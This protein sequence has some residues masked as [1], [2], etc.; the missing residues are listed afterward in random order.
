MDNP[1]DALDI[2][3]K[4]LSS[5]GLDSLGDRTVLELGPGNSSLTAL[6][7]RSMGAT[8]TWLVDS[9]PLASQDVRIFGLAERMLEARHFPGTGIRNSRTVQA[10]LE[11]L[12]T[13]YSTEGL[14]SL[15]AIPD[16]SVDFLFSNAVMEH[17]RLCDFETTAREMRRV[18]KPDGVASHQIDF[19][20]H[21][22]NALNN[23]RFSE[24]MW[25]SQFMA[26]SG[27]YT[28]RL[29]WPAMAK[30]FGHAGFNV[31][32]KSADLWP[33]GLPTP[34]RRMARPFKDMAAEDL[35]VKGAHVVLRP[36]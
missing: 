30:I 8:R 34:Q 19:R 18:L 10:A 6:F 17:I 1:A 4:H 2:F 7:A 28:N 16:N 31:E 22:Q 32:L 11:H 15:R 5:T 27:F 14:I 21:L 23:L 33:N 29:P 13:V 3:M 26:R 25:E 12:N 36:L 20:D 9:E 35:R 24:N